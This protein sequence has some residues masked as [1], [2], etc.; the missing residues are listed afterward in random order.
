M[1]DAASCTRISP[2]ELIS[3][4]AAVGTAG[5]IPARAL[6]NSRMISS[7]WGAV[8]SPFSAMRNFD[9]FF[10][11]VS[12]VLEW[13]LALPSYLGGRRLQ[14]E[15]HGHDRARAKPGRVLAQQRETDGGIEHVRQRLSAAW[16]RA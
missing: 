15:E 13:G 12:R 14:L 6:P 8:N 11:P 4:G 3:P 1:N 9:S 7:T 10:M 16:G 2:S 5:S